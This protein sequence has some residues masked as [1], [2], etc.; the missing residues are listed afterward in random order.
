[1]PRSSALSTTA[2][3]AARSRRSPKLLVPTPTMETRGPPAP[4]VRLCTGLVRRELELAGVGPPF[5]ELLLDVLLEVL[6]A[7][8]HRHGVELG[9]GARHLGVRHRV[10]YRAVEARD[11]VGGHL[12][13]PDDA[14]EGVG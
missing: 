14:E 12:R 8:A 10:L 6:R 4:S 9:E 3:E 1:M 13:R 2:R 11:H 5:A 7:A